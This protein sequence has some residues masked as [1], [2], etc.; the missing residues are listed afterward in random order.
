MT[1][2]THGVLVHTVERGGQA[3]ERGLRPGDIIQ[4]VNLQP[5]RNVAEF[6]DLLGGLPAGDSVA[7]FVRRGDGSLFLGL[8]LPEGDDD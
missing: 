7:L 6:N 5:V 2:D 4:E 3:E 8:R 1:D